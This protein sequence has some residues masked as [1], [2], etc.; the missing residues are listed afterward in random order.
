MVPGGCEPVIFQLAVISIGETGFAFY[1][2]D[3]FLDRIDGGYRWE[4]DTPLE[5]TIGNDQS[6]NGRIQVV[7]RIDPFSRCKHIDRDGY[8]LQLAVLERLETVVMEGSGKGISPDLIRQVL[9]LG[10]QCSDTPPELIFGAMERNKTCPPD[11]GEGSRQAV[12][13]RLVHNPLLQIMSDCI[14]GNS[15]IRGSRLIHELIFFHQVDGLLQ[16]IFGVVVFFM[17]LDRAIF[18]IVNILF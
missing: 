17:V 4:Q 13:V 15:G 10:F 12:R 3:L 14:Q 2:G 16:A 5:L 8:I 6:E 18:I 1:D 11:G 7:G 9:F